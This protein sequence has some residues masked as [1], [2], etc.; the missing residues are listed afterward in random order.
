MLRTT[1][2]QRNCKKKSSGPSG[3]FPS[4]K[5]AFFFDGNFSLT[6]VTTTFGVESPVPADLIHGNLPASDPVVFLGEVLPDAPPADGGFFEERGRVR[7]ESVIVQRWK[8]ATPVDTSAFSSLSMKSRN[9]RKRHSFLNGT[10]Q[11]NF[12][13]ILRS[14]ETSVPP[15]HNS[16]QIGSAD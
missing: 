4:N 11:E 7:R 5:P 1:S 13:D 12:S 16:G 15:Y 3:I 9:L 10:A 6:S 8:V 14:S 2:R